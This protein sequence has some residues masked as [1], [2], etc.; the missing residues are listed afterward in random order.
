MTTKRRRQIHADLTAPVDLSPLAFELYQRAEAHRTDDWDILA[1]YPS[2]KARKLMAS[3]LDAEDMNMVSG[4][5]VITLYE[6][7][8]E[9]ADYYDL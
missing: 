4:E 6:I 5:E 7:A 8:A 9:T 1:T 2:L 3:L